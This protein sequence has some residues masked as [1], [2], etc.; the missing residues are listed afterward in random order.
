MDS[1]ILSRK[2]SVEFV[3]CSVLFCTCLITANALESKQILLDWNILGF[4][5]KLG[6]T[7][8]LLVFPISYILND[9]ITEVF[10]WGKTKLVI[11]LGFAMNLFFIVFGA[12]ADIIPGAPYWQ[13]QEGFHSIFGLVP[14]IAAGSLIAFLVG[15]FLNALVMDKMRDGRHFSVRAMVSTLVGETADSIV[16]FPIALGGVV[17]FNELLVIMITQIFL[18]TLYEFLALPITIRVVKLLKIKK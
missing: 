2:V 5:L 1:S 16:F 4:H 7:G 12:L 9:C 13:M 17:P 8:G 15:S 18:K 10:G 11:W 14:R 3:I 6:L